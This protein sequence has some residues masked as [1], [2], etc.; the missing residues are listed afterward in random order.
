M[1]DLSPDAHSGR[2]LISVGDFLQHGFVLPE[3]TAALTQVAKDFRLRM[4]P[5]M[6]AAG[7]PGV[8]RQ[9]VPSVQELI[10]RPEDLTDPIGD[11]THAPVPGLT[12]RYPDRVILHVTK[13]CE[14]YCRFCF[15]RETVGETGHLP[16]EALT[17][18]LDYIART[19]AIW[20]VVLTGGDPLV[21]SAR[22][23][24]DLLARIAAIPHV[25][26]VRFH[27]RV[28]VVAPHRIT[29]ALIAALKTRLTPWIVIHTNH[30]DE[31][32]ENA[33]AALASLADAGIPLLS[34]SVLLK[35]VNDQVETLDRLFRRLYA[36]RVKPYYLH[37]CDLARGASH[38]RTTIAAG[39]ALIA[40]LR[41]HLPG[42]CLPTYILDIPGGYGKSPIGPA[43]LSHH[44]AGHWDVLDWRGQSHRYSDPA[45]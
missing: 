39:Q 36:L 33:T 30:P 34:Q 4:S 31:L 16:E 41:G 27:T 17:Q 14:V 18:A 44:G 1:T 29:P 45:A 2:A 43:Y 10:E 38:F 25:A 21:L 11:D 24:S 5:E 32:T 40:A 13:T 7:S 37:H 22:R 9:F 12:H 6:A 26:V 35:G 28:P 42:P 3:Q 8:A 19:P 15:R 23:L 20:E